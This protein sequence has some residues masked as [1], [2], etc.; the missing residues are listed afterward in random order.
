MQKPRAVSNLNLLEA[1]NQVTGRMERF[2]AYI[3][4]PEDTIRASTYVEK[5]VE[6][7]VDFFDVGPEQAKKNLP[8]HIFIKYTVKPDTYIMFEYLPLPA[9]EYFKLEKMGEPQS[10]PRHVIIILNDE[11]YSE[12][13]LEDLKSG[14]IPYIR[15]FMK[16]H[17]DVNILDEHIL[18]KTQKEEARKMYGQI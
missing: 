2:Q 3:L 7:G 5:Q 18:I 12:E 15:E 14:S 13:E 1:Q 8:M 17:Q 11:E 10:Y 4:S 16:A 9:A 6:A